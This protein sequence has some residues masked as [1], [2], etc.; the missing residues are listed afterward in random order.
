MA[1][2]DPELRERLRLALIPG[3]GPRLRLALLDAFGTP[4]AALAA[5][6]ERLRQVPGIGRKLSE[7]IGAA[8]NAEGSAAERLR[9]AILAH[10]KVYEVYPA[11]SRA[12]QFD[13]G[14]AARIPQIGQRTD[15][16]F[17]GPV[18]K[19]LVDGAK[20]G[21]LRKV[22][23]PRLAAV[24]IL[25]AVTTVA[26]NAIAPGATRRLDEVADDLV[27]VVLRGVSP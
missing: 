12:L 9:A 16:A 1:A 20:D 13:L 5:S 18:R 3:I 14:R 27:D 24:A 7:A 25:G 22:E 4:S 11:A 10:L 2:D 8:V 17:L 6:P 15:A 21:S 23:H 19:L 26:I